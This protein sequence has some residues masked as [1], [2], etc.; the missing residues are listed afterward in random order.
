MEYPDCSV[1]WCISSGDFVVL[2][3]DFFSSFYLYHDQAVKSMLGKQER[4]YWEVCSLVH[5]MHAADTFK[6]VVLVVFWCG[7]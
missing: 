3:Q 5:M 7:S 2:F 4:H 6:R 1:A